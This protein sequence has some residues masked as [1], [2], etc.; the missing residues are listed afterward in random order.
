MGN[1]MTYVMTWDIA[2]RSNHSFKISKTDKK[3][4]EYI[5]PKHDSKFIKSKLDKIPS[6]LYLEIESKKTI[7]NYLTDKGFDDKT[8]HYISEVEWI[9]NEKDGKFVTSEDGYPASPAQ[10]GYDEK[11]KKSVIQ[12]TGSKLLVPP[13]SSH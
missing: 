4:T 2:G 9:K 12:D 7:K 1:D 10:P 3:I 8:L 5:T 6:D 13:G 11:W